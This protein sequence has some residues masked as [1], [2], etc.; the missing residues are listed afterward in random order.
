MKVNVKEDMKTYNK[1]IVSY[2]V[3][4]SMAK[5]MR[6]GM[7]EVQDDV[8]KAYKD[9]EGYLDIRLTIEGHEIDFKAFCERWQSDI[10]RQIKEKAKQLVELNFADL[11]DVLHD[12]E[13]TLRSEVSKRMEDWEKEGD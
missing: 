10:R 2:I 6:D 1:G 4:N 7:D 13:Q 5:A 3:L 8:L 9:N 12:L 11:Y